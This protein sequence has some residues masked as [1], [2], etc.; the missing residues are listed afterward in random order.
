MRDWKAPI[1]AQ[2]RLDDD[3][4]VHVDFIAELRKAITHN[5]G[6]LDMAGALQ[7]IFAVAMLLFQAAWALRPPP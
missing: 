5:K 7:S 1:C 3:D 4:A 2:F 6:L